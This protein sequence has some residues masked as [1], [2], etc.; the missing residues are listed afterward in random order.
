MHKS[1]TIDNG[2]LETLSKTCL[3]PLETAK[4][5]ST[6]SSDDREGGAALA[7]PVP[8]QPPVAPAHAQ[9]PS[10]AALSL[11]DNDVPAPVEP[12]LPAA[13]NETFDAT[14][15]DPSP[16]RA[17]TDVSAHAYSY[18]PPPDGSASLAYPPATPHLTRAPVAI[19]TKDPAVGRGVFATANI[20]VGEV[21]EI[22]PVL[23]LG[24]EEYSGRKKGEESDG[25]LRGVEASQLRG[26]VFSWGRDGSMAV[27]LGL[28]SL[29]N[30][31]SSPNVSYTLDPAQYTISYRAAKPI[32]AG[33]ELCIF[34]GHN[35]SF[36]GDAASAVPAS[37]VIDDGWG[38]LGGLD[39]SVGPAASD[40]GSASS[41]E[42]SLAEL[43][44]LT[45]EDLAERDNEIVGFNE[46]NFPWRKV[47]D[48]IDPEDAVLT[49][50]SCL[51]ITIAA[52]YSAQVFQFVRKHSNRKFNELGHLK[53]VK[54]IDDEGY[55][56]L[57]RRA[58]QQALERNANGSGSD[59]EDGGAGGPGTPGSPSSSS[60]SLSSSSL[61]DRSSR[62]RAQS[63]RTGGDTL[64][65][66]LLF[67]VSS[68]PSNL[69]ELLASSP[70]A[71][72][73]GD[74]PIPEL[75]TV[76][77]PAQPAHTEEQAEEWSKLWPVQLVHIREGAKAT[78]RKRGWERGKMEWVE[79]EAK[80]V[81]KKAE[82]AGARGEHPIACHVTDSWAPGFHTSLKRPVTLVNA[83]DT[84]KSTGN[85]LAH[86]ACNAID[87]IGVLDLHGGR[88]PIQHLSPDSADPPY[89]LTGL[90][91]FMS[92]EPC[93]LCA[94]SLLHSRIKQLYYIK[95]APG[96]GGCGSLYNV[97]ED[98]GL[99]HRFEV[100]EWAGETPDGGIGSGKGEDLRCDP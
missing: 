7:P 81:W 5:S 53:R 52:R 68:A 65:R 41:S 45:V 49:T 43:K 25:S 64:Q 21:V 61:S 28:G 77:V 10:V 70:L 34:Y 51:A 62:P 86:A 17:V 57:K 13:F 4:T 99:N 11:S 83:A 88:P 40:A 98:G 9:L 19:M 8:L 20:H 31:S 84:R 47:S 48:I 63:V 27:A 23:V 78:R 37:P 1:P 60:L 95:R 54:P 97:H 90:T 24:P 100:W 76:D 35:V 3:H 58:M 46:E 80:K 18:P 96:A 33:E 79:K 2:L 71:T 44:Q 26:Y 85:V 89:L 38:G 67:P 66:V 29:F 69:P 92:H 50:V 12:Q 56:A 16:H 30:H 15:N 32:S 91:V 75:Y 74:E 55:V 72:A 14:P 39:S 42:D 22:S 93:L 6:T 87:A 36:A 59:S 82:E 73:L 94:M